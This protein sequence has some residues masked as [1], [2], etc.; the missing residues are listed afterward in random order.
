ME[1]RVQLDSRV[2]PV[3]LEKGDRLVL[4]VFGEI[5][6]PQV[7]PEDVVEPVQ[8]EWMVPMVWMVYPVLMVVTVRTVNQVVLGVL[9]TTVERAVQV[10]M[11]TMVDLVW[12]DLME[13][14]V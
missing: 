4:W 10:G 8:T 13:S 2:L 6:A 3:S 12:L 7:A 5:G 9:A 1:K 11:E 14:P